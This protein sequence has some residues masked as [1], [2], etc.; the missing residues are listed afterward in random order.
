MNEQNET[1]YRTPDGLPVDICIFTIISEPK[2][3]KNK[4][5]PHK[6][7]KILLIKRKNEPFETYWA[8]PG[9]FSRENETLAESAY[10]ELK[11]ETNVDKN[12]VHIEQLKTYYYPGRD[13]RGW[14]P[15]VAFA[16]LVKEEFLMNIKADTDAAEVGLFNVDEALQMKLAFDHNVILEDALDAIREKMLTTN[17][18][19]KFLPP[20]FT[21]NELYQIIISVVP[22]FDVEKTNFI[23]K[24]V[25]TKS[26]EGLLKEAVDVNGNSKY[27]DK[28]SQRKAKLYTFTGQYPRLSIYNSMQ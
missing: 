6:D 19:K 9:G 1:K 8:I 11:E 24:I 21:I 16:A 22:D 25:A 27:S 7:L 15:S 26:R 3:T 23:K 14:M 28:Y 12:H 18:A 5:L 2:R 4:Y 17:I 10:R 20:E 13:P